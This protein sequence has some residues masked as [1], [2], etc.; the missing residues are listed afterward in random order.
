[1]ICKKC[2]I[3]MVENTDQFNETEM[4]LLGPNWTHFKCTKCGEGTHISSPPYADGGLKTEGEMN[5]EQ[6]ETI[7]INDD[8]LI[9]SGEATAIDDMIEQAKELMKNINLL[10]EYAEAIT[11]IPEKQKLDEATEARNEAQKVFD[12][13]IA[14]INVPTIEINDQEEKLQ[15]LL[16]EI[17]ERIDN[18]DWKKDPIQ[19]TKKRFEKNG[20]II[21]RSL[22]TDRK[23]IP[24]LFVKNH[25]LITNELVNEGK[26]TIPLK[27]AEEKLSKNDVNAVCTI[28]E[29]KTYELKINHRA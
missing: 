4:H 12:E 23:I 18:K 9:A 2:K 14:K 6:I 5:V 29:T 27:Y 26:I 3:E 8:D 17:G 28:K 21:V 20:A 15:N 11:D 7:T 16:K 10:K 25:P 22:R 19:K 1:M 24:E 13:A